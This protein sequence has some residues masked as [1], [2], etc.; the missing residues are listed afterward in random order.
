MP[1]WQSPSTPRPAISLMDDWLVLEK[2]WLALVETARTDIFASRDTMNTVR[3]ETETVFVKQVQRR[4]T[5][6][7]GDHTFHVK[8]MDK[9]VLGYNDLP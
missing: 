2:T 8:S 6:M 9:R 7:D 1:A 4:N 3:L 5:M